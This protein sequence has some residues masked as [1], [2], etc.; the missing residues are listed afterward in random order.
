M[1]NQMIY[2]ISEKKNYNKT[3]PKNTNIYYLTSEIIL[4]K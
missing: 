2:A 4:A 1:N 3:K